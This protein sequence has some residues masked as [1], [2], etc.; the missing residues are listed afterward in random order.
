M[1]THFNYPKIELLIDKANQQRE[2]NPRAFILI[3]K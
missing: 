3:L 2:S 1:A